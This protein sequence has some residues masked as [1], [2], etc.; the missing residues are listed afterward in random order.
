M[1]ANQNEMKMKQDKNRIAIASEFIPQELEG[2]VE[3]KI[4]DMKLYAYLKKPVN[5]A[6]AKVSNI[7]NIVRINILETPP[8]C[9]FRHCA[10]GLK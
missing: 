8:A 3:F 1:V 6:E 10:R 5:F 4:F 2:L 7:I 9:I